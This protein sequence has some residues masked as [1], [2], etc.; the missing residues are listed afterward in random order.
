MLTNQPQCKKCRR[1]G[2][3]LFLK[4][5]KCEGAKCVFIKR[6]FAPGVHGT[7]K[8]SRPTNYGKQLLEKQKTKRMYGLR[9]TQFRNYFESAF[10]KIGN[11]AELLFQNLERRLDNTVYR[12]G[13]AD[14]RVQARQMV[15]HGHFT[16]NGR[17]MDIPSYQV[18]VGDIISVKE[19]Y[20]K[21][22]AYANRIETL[23]KKSQVSWLNF[24][25]TDMKAKVTALPKLGDVS[26]NVDWRTIIEFYSK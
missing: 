8:M 13:F 2:E 18:K 20:A 14:S 5:E 21:S 9:E 24:N 22:K 19:K 26:V 10:K 1:A 11:T 16:I 6:N 7:K 17:K 4:G 12:L 3:K 23:K 15:N 25:T